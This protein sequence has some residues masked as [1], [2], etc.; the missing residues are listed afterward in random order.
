MVKE[1]C[2]YGL[3]HWGSDDLGVEKTRRFFLE[4]QSF[5]CRYVRGLSVCLAMSVCLLVYVC[6]STCV[7]VSA[8]FLSACLGCPSAS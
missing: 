5:L 2:D 8:F 6:L 3:E 1:F 4:W 7:C